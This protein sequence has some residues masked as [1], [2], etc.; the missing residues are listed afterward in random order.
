MT[1]QF[2]S[3]IAGALVALLGVLF[4]LRWNQRLHEENL[5]EE[6]EKAR[7]EREFKA[8]QDALLVAAEAVSHYITYY[9]T[10]ADRLLPSDGTVADEVAEIGV[11][12]N[13]LHFYCNLET[14]EKSTHLGQI[15]GEVV[16]EAMKAKM[17]S[18]FTHEELK[19]IDVQTSSFEK[20]NT[21]IQGEIQALLQ[22]DP[23]NQI[24]ISHIEQLPKNFQTITEL[25][26]NKVELFKRKYIET[27]K[28]RDVIKKNLRIIYESS[29]DVLLLARKELAFPIDETRYK[30]IMDERIKSMEASL[31]SLFSEIRKQVEEKMK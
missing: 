26:N 13:R 18:A 1:E 12:L 23:N 11:A 14:I 25:Y 31:E 3:T 6:R 10:L 30:E 22:A 9:I 29:R 15:L 16:S 17:P 2:Y 24:L 8:K 28:C 20:I 21:V 27:E 7:K 4:T 5:R 19:A